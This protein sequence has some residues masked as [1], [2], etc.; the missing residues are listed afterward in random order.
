VV[1]SVFGIHNPGV[2]GSNPP[3]ATIQIKRLGEN[4]V[5]FL[6]LKFL[7]A[8]LRRTSKKNSAIVAEFQAQKSRCYPALTVIFEG[9]SMDTVLDSLYN[10]EKLPEIY[11]Y[12]AIASSVIEV[13]HSQFNLLITLANYPY[14]MV[15]LKYPHPLK[16]L[17]LTGQMQETETA[18]Q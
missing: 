15:K 8:H 1:F 12:F 17:A 10:F 6:C 3:I 4:Q 14:F 16:Q 9:F 7:K 11:P 13:N 5:L 18:A 2:G